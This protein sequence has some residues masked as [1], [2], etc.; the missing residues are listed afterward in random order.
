MNLFESLVTQ[1]AVYDH[2]PWNL[3]TYGLFT[4][5][6]EYEPSLVTKFT[7]QKGIHETLNV[8]ARVCDVPD[9]IEGIRN[10][11]SRFSQGPLRCI[12]P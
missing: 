11:G 2:N 1:K 6:F 4:R 7:T 3:E 12:V 8:L 9:G 5:R 10:L